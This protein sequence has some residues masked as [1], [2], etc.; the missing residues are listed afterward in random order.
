[1]HTKFAARV[2]VM[3]ILFAKITR[4]NI[5]TPPTTPHP[6]SYGYTLLANRSLYDFDDPY[7]YSARTCVGEVDRRGL[8]RAGF[9]AFVVLVNGL[10]A[11]EIVFSL[12]RV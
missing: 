7:L 6:E 11:C 2:H 4:E 5:S 3:Y 10:E 9:V 12:F 1:M 8:P